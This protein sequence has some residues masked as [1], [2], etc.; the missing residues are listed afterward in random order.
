MRTASDEDNNA[1][2]RRQGRSKECTLLAR[3]QKE[4]DWDN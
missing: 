1:A 4:V 2:Q 3:F